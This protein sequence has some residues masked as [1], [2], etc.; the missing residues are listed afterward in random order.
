[1]YTPINWANPNN[2]E[3]IK[4]KRAAERINHPPTIEAVRQRKETKP[5]RF[6]ALNRLFTVKL[7]PIFDI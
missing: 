2:L 3:I 6:E 5:K 1:M 7:K 4:E